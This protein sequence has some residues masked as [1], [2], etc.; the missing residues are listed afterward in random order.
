MKSSATPAGNGASAN[1]VE[2]CSEYGSS[3]GEWKCAKCAPSFFLDVSRNRCEYTGLPGCVDFAYSGSSDPPFSCSACQDRLFLKDGICHQ[4][5]PDCAKA[6]FHASFAGVPSSSVLECLQCAP[7]K[8]LGKFFTN[9]SG[10]P[11]NNCFRKLEH[12]ISINTNSQ[13]ELSAEAVQAAP[14]PSLVSEESRVSELTGNSLSFC[15]KRLVS[16]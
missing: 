4:S 16:E 1:A 3:A 9:T 6:Q 10:N 5:I 11:K 12:S 2:F 8:T 13:N 7:Q 15:N 14:S